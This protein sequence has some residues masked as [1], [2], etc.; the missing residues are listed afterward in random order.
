MEGS[1]GRQFQKSRGEG[2][3]AGMEGLEE[4]TKENSKVR[5]GAESKDYGLGGM[6]VT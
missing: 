5:Q 2:L 6:A 3:R 4:S 1:L